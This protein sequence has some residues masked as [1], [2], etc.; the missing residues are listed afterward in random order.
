MCW[1]KIKICLILACL[2]VSVC[3]CQEV[4][5]EVKER[6]ETYGENRQMAEEQ[7]NR[8]TIKSKIV[9]FRCEIR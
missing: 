2:T 4:P 7:I 5:Q 8:C 9:G 1:R 3:G 6:M